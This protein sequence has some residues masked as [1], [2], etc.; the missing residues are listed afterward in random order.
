M[1]TIIKIILAL[2]A[3][4]SPAFSYGG[5][6]PPPFYSAKTH[7]A[8]FQPPLNFS[9]ENQSVL[10]AHFTYTAAPDINGR[11]D[12]Q[13]TGTDYSGLVNG[14]NFEWD[15]PHMNFKMGVFPSVS[16]NTSLLLSFHGDAAEGNLKLNGFDIGLTYN[17]ISRDDHYVRFGF[18]LDFHRNDFFWVQ[19]L[20]SP[21]KECINFDYDPFIL[22]LYNANRD[23]WLLNPF[24]QISFCRQTLL[25]DDEYSTSDYDQEV[26]FNMNIITFTPGLNY[27]WG[28]NKLISFGAMM[29]YYD[30]IENS[31]QFLLTPFVQLNLQL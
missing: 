9:R 25:D 18:G 1:K 28:N 11:I 31:R 6:P 12:L 10:F 23:D 27:K 19:S 24:F 29:Y 26:Y 21:A 14:K 17:V 2:T 5:P 8:V 20:N 3:C 4:Y 13:G 22:L 15:L 16:E 7:N 30:G